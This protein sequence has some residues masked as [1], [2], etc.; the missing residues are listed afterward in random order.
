MQTQK[1]Y[2]FLK[3]GEY[4]ELGDE[5]VTETQNGDLW[6]PVGC[7]NILVTH[8]DDNDQFYRRITRVIMD[9]LTYVRE[10]K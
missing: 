1:K 9:G 7:P 4:T 8:K 10:S 5:F 2:R 3:A 6:T